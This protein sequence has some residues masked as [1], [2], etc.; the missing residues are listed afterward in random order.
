[1]K[2]YVCRVTYWAPLEM[3]SR[4]PK[5]CQA[6]LAQSW[7]TVTNLQPLLLHLFCGQ[8]AAFYVT[9]LGRLYWWRRG[10]LGWPWSPLHHSLITRSFFHR[11]LLS[12]DL[13]WPRTKDSFFKRE[14]YIVAKCEQDNVW[15]DCFSSVNKINTNL[16]QTNQ[17]YC[18]WS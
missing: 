17:Y 7:A 11:T 1:M 4:K 9:Q 2:K 12:L 6:L 3:L 8:F 16:N 10:D 5:F 15:I 13:I 14:L 18:V